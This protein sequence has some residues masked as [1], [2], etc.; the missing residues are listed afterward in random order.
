MA[1]FIASLW[2]EDVPV[3]LQTWA[4]QRLGTLMDKALAKHNLESTTQTYTYVSARRLL[5]CVEGLP[6]RLAG[7]RTEKVGPALSAPKAAVEGFLRAH[8]VK[9]IEDKK[10]YHTVEHT[11]GTLVAVTVEHPSRQ[12]ATLLPSCLESVLLGLHWHRSMRWGWSA[13]TWVRPLIGIEASFDGK[14]LAGGFYLGHSGKAESPSW[15]AKGKG[16]DEAL[17]LPNQ[18]RDSQRP[19]I[20][21][22]AYLAQLHKRGIIMDSGERQEHLQQGIH[23]VLA[24]HQLSPRKDDGLLAVCAHFC[25]RPHPVLAEMTPETM[26]LPPE[27]IEVVMRGQQ[28]NIP[29]YDKTGTLSRHFIAV[30]DGNNKGKAEKTIIDGYQRVLDARL[31]DARF[32]IE[33]DMSCELESFVGDG[34]D[35]I[36]YHAKLGSMRDKAHRLRTIAGKLADSVGVDSQQAGRAGYLAKADL[37]SQ[38][39][40]EFP[41][42]QGVMGSLYVQGSE[43]LALAIRQHY[44]PVGDEQP[45]PRESLGQLIALADKLDH[46]VGFWLL[47]E[48]PTASK[49]PYALRRASVGVVRL[50]L[51][52]RWSLVL[53]EVCAMI[54]ALYQE[55]GFLKDKRQPQSALAELYTYIVGRLRGV[56]QTEGLPLRAIDATLSRQQQQTGGLIALADTAR[57]LSAFLADDDKKG[58]G[59]LISVYRRV[60]RIVQQEKSDKGKVQEAA[61]QEKEEKQLYRAYQSLSQQLGKDETTR[62]PIDEQLAGLRALGVPLHGFFERVHVNCEDSA[63]RNNRLRLL[64]GVKGLFDGVADF[65]TLQGKQES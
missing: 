20:T 46:L 41:Q 36:V 10:N 45:C 7:S 2:M 39:V 64:A 38:M 53:S 52:S 30:V 65:A 58:E 14:A 17:F 23:K 19:A 37:A 8:G 55:Q 5:V 25:E 61:L 56:L 13:F 21:H 49:D 51:T 63:L 18:V 40:G 31:T 62:P 32:F 3:P 1:D 60:E 44:D 50:C 34:L 12:V 48:K 28:K 35:G 22:K 6:T 26:T 15:R 27:V 47:G 43:S 16:L 9:G 57:T 29:L 33:R 4:R 42:L 24:K 54:V 59:G 11:R